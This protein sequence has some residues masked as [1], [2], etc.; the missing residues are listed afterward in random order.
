MRFCFCFP[1]SFSE[2]FTIFNWIFLFFMDRY[3]NY[4]IN[5]RWKRIP[6]GE[7]TTAP[8][9]EPEELTDCWDPAR[10][11][12]DRRRRRTS[13]CS[14]ATGSGFG[15]W[16]SR[17]RTT[18]RLPLREPQPG[19]T[20]GS[21][22]QTGTRSNPEPQRWTRTTATATLTYAIDPTP[23][24]CPLLSAFSGKLANFLWLL[25]DPMIPSHPPTP[26]PFLKKF[27]IK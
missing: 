12:F 2:A 19:S 25:I 10:R 16:R 13:C 5:K 7:A 1:F 18:R 26:L 14:G 9:A 24:P 6:S 4:R 11:L 22:G 15:A 17:W 21:W 27:K 3:N 20:E 23:L 8:R